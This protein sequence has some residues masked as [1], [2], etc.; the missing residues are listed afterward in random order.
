[1]AADLSALGVRAGDTILLHS[2]LRAVGWVCGGPAAV[3]HAFLDVLGDRGTLAVFAQTSDNRDPSRWSHRPV[4]EEWWPVIRDHLPGFDPAISDCRAMGLVAETVRTWPGAVRSA[5]P[6]T[7]FVAIGARAADLMAVHDLESELGE[8]S[9]LAALEAAD[10]R[11]LLL[12]VGYDRCT[13]LH[14]AEY[15]LPWQRRRPNRCVVLGPAGRRWLDYQGMEL[16]A[17]DFPVIGAELERG[18]GSV[19]K[20]AVGGAAARF[21]RIREAV[22]YAVTWMSEHRRPPGT[23]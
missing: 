7:S 22:A 11:T 18:N 19:V 23:G 16:N 14:L 10:A 17:D 1:M 21:L 15:R 8:S 9:P 6:Q 4:P 5:H 20:G 12:G 13:A 3:V 2:S